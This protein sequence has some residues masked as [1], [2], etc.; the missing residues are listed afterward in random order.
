MAAHENHLGG[1]FYN[2]D[3]QASLGPI[4]SES[5]GWDPGQIVVKAPRV[6]PVYIQAQGPL[7]YDLAIPNVA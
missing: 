4:T 2:P 5:L 6:I 3:V 7:I 1:S